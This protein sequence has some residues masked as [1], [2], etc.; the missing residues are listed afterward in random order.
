M[1]S[2]KRLLLALSLVLASASLA[3]AE[4][5]GP[6]HTVSHVRHFAYRGFPVGYRWGYRPWGYRSWGYHFRPRFHYYRRP[7][8]A[9]RP[10]RYFHRPFYWGY[11]PRLYINYYVQPYL[12][13]ACPPYGYWSSYSPGVVPAPEVELPPPVEPAVKG[14]TPMI[15]S[16]PFA[17]PDWSLLEYRPPAP[18]RTLAAPA[19]TSS[20][21]FVGYDPS[22]D[23]V[24]DHVA[25]G[26]E[27]FRSGRFSAALDEYELG[28]AANP[29]RATLHVR[30]AYALTAVDRPSEAAT[31][32][33][34][35]LALDSSL[36][37]SGF[38]SADLYGDALPDR[39]AHLEKVAA[40]ALA[41][42]ENSD[43]LL[44]IGAFL[45]FNGE[46]ERARL[47]FDRVRDP[48]PAAPLILA[49]GR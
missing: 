33:R 31:A 10:Y 40:A 17:T 23:S 9:F 12:A 21:W 34:R 11:R 13:P 2:I 20:E 16:R 47:F 26:D 15:A 48:E 41:D 45:R 46:S 4:F 28:I 25:I 30:R 36:F 27:F 1:R 49:G 3:H 35:A 29:G 7:Y 43:L 5:G 18:A 19:T 6:W 24:A 32:L 39:T 37:R 8:F 44:L 42:S 38:R 22:H 14:A